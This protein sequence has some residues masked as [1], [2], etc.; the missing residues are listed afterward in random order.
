MTT[1]E[2]HILSHEEHEKCLSGAKAGRPTIVLRGGDLLINMNALSTSGETNE[3][4]DEEILRQRMTLRLPETKR[5]GMDK[6][7]LLKV[8]E[9]VYA[10]MGWE[11]HECWCGK[12]RSKVFVR[13][14]KKSSG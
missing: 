8:H 13:A 3:L 4:T 9:E 1:G 10:K 7:K 6:S 11:H 12:G 14:T 2:K 5:A